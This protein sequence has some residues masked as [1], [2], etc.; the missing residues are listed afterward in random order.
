MRLNASEVRRAA[1]ACGILVAALLAASCGGGGGSLNNFTPTRIIAFGDETSVIDDFQGDGNGRKYGI[2][3]TVSD[4]DPTLIC[5]ANPIWIQTLA[6]GYGNLVFPECNP[7]QGAVIDPPSRIRAAFGAM[8]ADLSL[9]IDAQ[10][11]ES[12]FQS[13][14]LATVLVGVN[15]V[16]AQYQQYPT[17]SEPVLTANVEAAGTEVGNQVNRLAAAGVK[18]IVSTIPDIGYSPFALAEKMS[19]IDTDR[20][21]LI[22]RLTDRFN[23]AMRSTIVNDGH[24]VGLVTINEFMDTIIPFPGVDGFTDVTDGACDLSRSALTPPSILDCTDFTL[25]SGATPN[26]YVWADDRHLSYG[27]QLSLGN[28][29]LSRARNNPF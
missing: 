1:S 29:A 2:N 14:D 24:F 6:S 16:I 15:D 18:V 12:P 9:Q 19:H 26:N 27:M 20:Q 17:L 7:S 23:A 28:L 8:A 13:G 10:L 25:V 21:Q 5:G 11:N 22:F 3:A 4:T